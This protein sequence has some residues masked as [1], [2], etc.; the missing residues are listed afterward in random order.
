MAYPLRFQPRFHKLL[1]CVI[2][3]PGVAYVGV[4]AGSDE[5]KGKR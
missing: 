2:N 5:I 4:V 1:V 3:E